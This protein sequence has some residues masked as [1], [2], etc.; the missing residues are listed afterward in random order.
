MLVLAIGSCTPCATI[1][2]EHRRCVHCLDD[3][4]Q[5]AETPCGASAVLGPG[6]WYVE[7]TYDPRNRAR[8][9]DKGEARTAALEPFKLYVKLLMTALG[10]VKSC[11]ITVWR[12]VKGN[13]AK[14]YNK[15][16]LKILWGL[17]RPPTLR[18]SLQAEA[19]PCLLQMPRSR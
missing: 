12:G 6:E 19:C 10:K 7:S 16:E 8:R 4:Q 17:S 2:S 18:I 3:A 9:R 11:A 14:H 1:T 15:G 5:G 13:V